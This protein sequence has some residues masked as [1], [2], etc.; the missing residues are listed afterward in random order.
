MLSDCPEMGFSLLGDGNKSSHCPEM[1]FP[2][3]GDDNRL[4]VSPRYYVVGFLPLVDRTLL[5]EFSLPE[6]Q[7]CSSV[8]GIF[9]TWK[10]LRT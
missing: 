10:H 4:Q 6:S 2:L 1:E 5:Q 7:F 8:D 3:L 9:P